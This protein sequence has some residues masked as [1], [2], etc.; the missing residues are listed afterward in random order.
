M[1]AAAQN[2]HQHYEHGGHEGHDHHAMMV[3][4]FKRRLWVSLA[5]TLPILALSPMIQ[6]FL[7][8]GEALC[9]TGISTCSSASRRSSSSTADGPF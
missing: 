7:G 8:L 5:L 6:G 1:E 9:F 3:L 4:D 2:G